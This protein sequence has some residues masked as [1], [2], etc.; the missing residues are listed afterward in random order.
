MIVLGC[1]I[2]VCMTVVAVTLIRS[3]HGV[4]V[5]AVNEDVDLLELR[6]KDT[7]KSDASLRAELD[8]LKVVVHGNATLLERV[9]REK[10][11]SAIAKVLP[12]GAK[13]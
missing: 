6:V 2:I 13:S 7:E 1:V 11:N 3:N 5:D 10:T 8:A 9:T 4:D 12:V